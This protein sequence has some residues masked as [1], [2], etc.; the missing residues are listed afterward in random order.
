M[1]GPNNAIGWCDFTANPVRGKCLHNCEGCY[2]EAIRKRFRMKEE[3]EFNDNW[4]DAKAAMKFG[5]EEGRKPFIF[6][7]SMHDVFGEWIPGDWIKKVIRVCVENSGIAHFMFLTQ[8]PS[9][10]IE[11]DFPGNNMWLGVTCRNEDEFEKRIIRNIID[12]VSFEPLLGGIESGVF[13]LAWMKWAIIGCKTPYDKRF[14]FDEAVALID[15][16]KMHDIPIW[17][18][19]LPDKNGRADKNM[20]HWPKFFRRRERPKI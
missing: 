8:N 4:F 19:Q 11:F 17:V 16:L 2:A 6:V 20:K 12:F 5:I 7:G 9:R 15:E 3:L 18:K 10:Y 1:N 13:R 14:D